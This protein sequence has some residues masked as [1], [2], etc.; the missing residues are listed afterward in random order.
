MKNKIFKNLSMEKKQGILMHILR[1]KT[2]GLLTVLKNECVN[3]IGSTY[4]LR[5]D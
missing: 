1:N 5:C 4:I 3:I 2:N